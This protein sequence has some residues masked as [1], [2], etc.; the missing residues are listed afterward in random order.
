MNSIVYPCFPKLILKKCVRSDRPSVVSI[1]R[2]HPPDWLL[3]N[4]DK[5]AYQKIAILR[6][7]ADGYAG[8][9]LHSSL[10]V[11]FLSGFSLTNIHNLRDCRE[12]GRLSIKFLSTTSTH[13][14]D[15]NLEPLVSERKCVFPFMYN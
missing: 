8:T 6:K 7:Y 10:C 9:S 15:S 12:R 5:N 11:F 3:H 1:T 4:A 14:T 2:N 13:L